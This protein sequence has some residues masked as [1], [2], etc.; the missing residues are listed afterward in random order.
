MLRNYL[1]IAFRNL[2]RNKVYSLINILG[3][4]L[5]IT[6]CILLTLYIADE[7]SYVKQHARLNDLYRI[8]SQ[9]EGERGLNSLTTTSPP[10]AMAMRDEIPEVENAVRIF[11]PPG[12]A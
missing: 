4:S 5:G 7:V 3:L 12:V 2:T 8:I 9:F 10:I 1:T 11:N 6:C